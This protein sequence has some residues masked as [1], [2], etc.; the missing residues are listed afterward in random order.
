MYEPGP[1]FE[2]DAFISEEKKVSFEPAGL[3]A[4]DEVHVQEIDTAEREEDKNLFAAVDAND[5]AEEIAKQ[6]RE[7]IAREKNENKEAA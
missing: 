4:G 1:K 7:R 6:M 5:R 2:P 3:T